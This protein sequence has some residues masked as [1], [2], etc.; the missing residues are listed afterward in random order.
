MG[1][2]DYKIVGANSNN[3]MIVP[4]YDDGGGRL[5]DRSL[6]PNFSNN[7]VSIG[8]AICFDI[9]IVGA[10]IIKRID[11]EVVA[12]ECYLGIPCE[13]DKYGA[14]TEVMLGRFKYKAGDFSSYF[15]PKITRR[16]LMVFSER[17]ELA[18]VCFK[19]LSPEYGL[20]DYGFCGI[21]HSNTD[22]KFTR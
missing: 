1:K 15:T 12:Y 14:P 5:E 17:D 10:Q 6:Y 20:D 4:I 8:K 16:K 11:D 22:K 7:G 2:N 3:C 21:E 9:S 19:A 13:F 18:N